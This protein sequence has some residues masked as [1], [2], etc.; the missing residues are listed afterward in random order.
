[1]QTKPDNLSNAKEG[2]APQALH[3]VCGRRMTVHPNYAIRSEYQGHT[4][5]F[6]TE[7]CLNAFEAEPERF[8]CAHSTQKS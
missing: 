5:Y 3:M 6:C 1:M 8:Y 7:S 4:I 2:I